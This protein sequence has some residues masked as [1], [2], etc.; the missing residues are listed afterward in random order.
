MIR[1][2][3]LLPDWVPM[4]TI[5]CLSCNSIVPILT[6]RPVRDSM[7]CPR[8]DNRIP[9]DDSALAQF[10]PTNRIAGLE[11]E[12]KDRRARR[13]S[14]GVWSVRRT[15]AVGIA[16][17]I[18]GLVVGVGYNL[19]TRSGKPP[20]TVEDA[21]KSI[22]P[23]EL[24]G[25]GY[26]PD[27]VDAVFAVH[28]ASL[29]AE[30]SARGWGGSPEEWTG[31]GL[32]EGILNYPEKLTGLKLTDIHHLVL[33]V[34][35]S[36]RNLP[37]EIVLIV[38][39]RKPYSID[40]L[41]SGMRSSNLRNDQNRNLRNVENPAVGLPLVWW[42]ANDRTLIVSLDADSLKDIP[43]RPSPDIDH[44]RADMRS[45][46][47]TQLAPDSLVWFAG[48]GDK[49]SEA[50]APLKTLGLLKG[51]DSLVR[52]I[53]KLRGLAA[54]VAIR[55]EVQWTTFAETDSPETA[56][57]WVSQIQKVAQNEMLEIQTGQP[58]NV[59]YFKLVLR[60]EDGAKWQKWLASRK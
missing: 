48:R 37:P 4:K 16:L 44:W 50:I 1:S 55:D 45:R 13:Q 22:P 42:P 14:S 23:A 15:F 21:V 57:D 41:T 33:G 30:V 49:L 60:S 28:C 35:W 26:L 32:P 39:T 3:L 10:Q 19:L 38:R 46:I 2:E 17:G 5:Q 8:C 24:G 7:I 18:L 29:L 47:R 53:D 31:L 25:L 43:D 54:G 56:R 52:G 6:D 40:S 51:R 58:G 9:L 36:R 59:C 27:D 11:S 34:R 20:I 12:V